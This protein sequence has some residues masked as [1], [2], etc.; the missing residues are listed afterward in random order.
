[1][2][3]PVPPLSED[4]ATRLAENLFSYTN[5]TLVREY[6]SAEKRDGHLLFRDPNDPSANLD[7]DLRTQELKFNK[8]MAPYK[9]DDDTSALPTDDS[10]AQL[11]LAHLEKLAMLPPRDELVL[12]HIGGVNMGVHRSD[13]STSLYHKLV[14]VRYN[15]TLGG[16]PVF[17]DSRV[18]LRLAEGGTLIGLTRRWI[19]VEAEKVRPDEV[20]SDQAVEQ[21]IKNQLLADGRSARRIVIKSAD[22]VMYDHGNGVIEPA[23]RVLASM[24]YEGKVV[25][26]RIVGEVRR[27]DVPYDTFVPVLKH[28]RTRYPFEHDPEAARRIQSDRPPRI[29]ERDE[30]RIDGED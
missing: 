1:V 18:V 28:H 21:G 6:D 30:P 27:L 10:A 23:I 14:V 12:A 8:G 29:R 26:S 2:A 16:L 19:P 25:N 20:L 24:H 9:N 13:G 4:R 5:A 17:G 22:L 11:A 7:I 15:R 3:K